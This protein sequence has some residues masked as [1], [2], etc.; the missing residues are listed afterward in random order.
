[1]VT[2]SLYAQSFLRSV[3]KSCQVR[4][5]QGS[6]EQ[7]HL[8]SQWVIK[9]SS[10]S[11]WGDWCTLTKLPEP[12]WVGRKYQFNHQSLQEGRGKPACPCIMGAPMPVQPPWRAM[13]SAQ[14]SSNPQMF[15]SSHSTSGDLPSR[16]NLYRHQETHT[17]ETQ[18]RDAYRST[19]CGS[20][21]LEMTLTYPRGTS[22]IYDSAC[23]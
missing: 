5:L 14:P 16:C 20:K 1:M 11:F 12:P 2:S 4:P 7:R 17:Q 21:S 10:V 18:I 19:I 15:F 23:R 8:S 9:R 3:A 6:G 13:A 22:Y